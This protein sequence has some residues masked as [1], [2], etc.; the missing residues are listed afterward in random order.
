M[1]EVLVNLPLK[2]VAGLPGDAP[3]DPL[4]TKHILPCLFCVKIDLLL[5]DYQDQLSLFK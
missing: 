4:G 1:A 5:P 2:L 3:M